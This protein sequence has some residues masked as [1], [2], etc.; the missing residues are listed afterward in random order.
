[1][2]ETKKLA[3]I[4]ASGKLAFATL[5]ALLSQNLLPAS[6]IVATTSATSS[7]AAQWQKLS[8][9]GVTVRHATFDD[10]ETI[11]SAL[12]DVSR[13]FLVSSPRIAMDFHN[14]PRGSGREKDH[15]AVI[16]AAKKAGVEHVYYTSLAFG[17]P[18]K[19]G[20]MRAHIVT[21]EYLEQQKGLDWTVIREGLYNESWPLYFGHWKVGEDD[22][23]E[24]EV[25][26]DSKINWTS[27]EDLGLANA[28]VLA[29]PREEWKHRTFYLS[30]TR[31]AKS[32]S[33][34]ADLVSKTLGREVKVKVVDRKEHED[35]Y[36]QQ[37]GMDEGMIKWWSKTY[38]SLRDEEC[39]IRDDTFEK[40]LSS[41]DV[42]PTPMEQTV[43]EMLQ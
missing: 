18:S 22:R 25:A 29:G 19:S 14:A 38:D 21:E 20:V 23:T 16:D 7:S 5:R 39:L 10:A 2:S 31:D 6:S 42:A 30:N 37:R 41:K 15:I 11:T 9:L 13:I 24:V 3:I 26:G 32:L 27:I 35:F 40:L 36:V 1:M 12:H 28:L 34:I 43:K 33:D 8:S 4:G 17:R